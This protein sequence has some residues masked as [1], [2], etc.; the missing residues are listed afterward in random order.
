MSSTLPTVRI[1]FDR[2]HTASKTKVGLV[3][4]EMLFGRKRKFISTG[5]RLYQGEWNERSHVVN[6]K[7]MYLLNK[8]IDGLKAKIDKYL[9]DLLENDTPFDFDAFTRWLATEN[10]KSASFLD[11]MSDRILERNLAES[12]K[13]SHR[14]VVNA[15][16]G[17]GKIVTFSDISKSAVI[18]FDDHL[19]SKGLKQSSIWS[20]HSTLRTYIGEAVRRGLLPA[21]P[22]SELKIE[23]GKSEWGKFLTK[24]ELERIMAT[25][26]PKVNLDRARDLFVIQCYT[27]MAYAD[28]MSFDYSRVKKNNGMFVYSTERVKTGVAFTT[29]LDSKVLDILKKYDNMLPRISSTQYSV[30]LKRMAKICG[31][32]KPIASHYGRRTCGMVLLNEGYPIEVVAKIL[33]HSNIKTTQDA[34]ARILD[35]TVVKEFAKRHKD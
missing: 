23:H 1:I 20:Y 10:E 6:R 30:L 31:I 27:G 35:D 17:F 8:R 16:V 18:R 28:I 33:G 12:T 26:M 21:S 22:Y 2:K 13:S 29:V 9:N 7:D 4:I 34:Y 11:W 25:P 24:E 15:L 14:K 3:Q 32:D 19:H 5:V